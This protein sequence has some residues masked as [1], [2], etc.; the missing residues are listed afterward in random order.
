MAVD[1][2]NR[3]CAW[4]E[5]VSEFEADHTTIPTGQFVNFISLASGP[6]LLLSGHLKEEILLLPVKKILPILCMKMKVP[7]M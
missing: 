4:L 2:G 5:P 6:P 3:M 7:S 1:F